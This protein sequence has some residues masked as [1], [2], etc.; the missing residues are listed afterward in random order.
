VLVA[1]IEEARVGHQGERF[2][3][4]IV[5]GFVHGWSK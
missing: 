5:E 3:A 2:F 4:E 1:H